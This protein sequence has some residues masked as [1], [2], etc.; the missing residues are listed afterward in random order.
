MELL[1]LHWDVT[2]LERER[3]GGKEGRKEGKRKAGLRVEPRR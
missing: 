1:K 2:R 3:D